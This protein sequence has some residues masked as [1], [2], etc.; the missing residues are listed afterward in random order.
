MFLLLR[1]PFRFRAWPCVRVW[2]PP[3]V[4]GVDVEGL[5][6]GRSVCIEESDRVL[7]SVSREVAVVTVDHGQAGAHVTGE[8]EGGDPGTECEGGEGMAEIVDPAQRLDPGRDL[9][10]LPLP[11]AKVVQVEVA[12]PLGGEHECALPTRRLLFD[13]FERDA[14]VLVT[15]AANY[16]EIASRWVQ[17]LLE[18]Y[19]K[20]TEVGPALERAAADIDELV[21]EPQDSNKKELT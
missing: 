20:P 13:C 10:R 2:C 1:G 8:V 4:H 18:A 3:S 17:G 5:G 15:P 9:R 21:L 7:A 6:L 12:T 11:V 19:T 14:F 16:L